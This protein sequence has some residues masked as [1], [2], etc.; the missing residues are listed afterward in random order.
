MRIELLSIQ[1]AGIYLA[2]III[3]FEFPRL[4]NN[5]MNHYPHCIG[6]KSGTE[7]W[8]G[9]E[10]L[11]MVAQPATS[12]A[13]SNPSLSWFCTSL[14]PHL[15]DGDA[16]AQTGESP[17]PRP[18]SGQPSV[19]GRSETRPLSAGQTAASS[20]AP[21]FSRGDFISLSMPLPQDQPPTAANSSDR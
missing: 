16:E 4:I 11:F 6:E 19:E 17:C 8:W 18:C 13:G 21:G 10:D 12:T 14:C 2:A 5:E 1:R 3:I 7:Q 9:G 20:Q 15:W